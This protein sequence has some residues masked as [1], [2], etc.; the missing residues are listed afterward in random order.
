M[1]KCTFSEGGKTKCI[2]QLIA[3][4]C[5]PDLWMTSPLFLH[6]LCSFTHDLDLFWVR[7][8][9]VPSR[10]L[11]WG[12]VECNSMNLNLAWKSL[13][14]QHSVPSSQDLIQHWKMCYLTF[15][16]IK[17]IPA[18]SQYLIRLTGNSIL[19]FIGGSSDPL[20]GL[21]KN[22]RSLCDAENVN[23]SM[24]HFTLLSEI[25]LFLKSSW[26]LEKSCFVL[27]LEVLVLR[28][29]PL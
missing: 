12:P 26:S 14:I 5:S 9:G 8:P 29:Q 23:T 11:P 13:L 7:N 18:L 17:V 25:G 4:R 16:W 15:L 1:Q 10:P 22:S 19:V 20:S 3:C 21:H 6:Y 2:S 24:L 27:R 28:V